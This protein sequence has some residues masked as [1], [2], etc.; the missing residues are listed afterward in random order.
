MIYYITNQATC[1]RTEKVMERAVL[2]TKG[3]CLQQ[4]LTASRIPSWKLLTSE[5]ALRDEAF[6]K[7]LVIFAEV[8]ERAS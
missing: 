2:D 1:R 4:A 7:H 6:T 5:M 3:L 8:L